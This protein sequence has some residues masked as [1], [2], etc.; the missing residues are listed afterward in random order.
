M[1]V[2]DF[3]R[4]AQLSVCDDAW[5]QLAERVIPMLESSMQNGA[6]A[7][8]R[9]GLCVV[10]KQLAAAPPQN[11]LPFLT[12]QVRGASKTLKARCDD[13]WGCYVI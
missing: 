8:G 1:V 4:T 5:T 10:L 7:Q 9:V 13:L 12:A 2:R 6:A 11:P 3:S